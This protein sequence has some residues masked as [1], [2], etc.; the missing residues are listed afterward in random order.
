MAKKRKIEVEKGNSSDSSSVDHKDDLAE[1]YE[2]VS[3]GVWARRT[4]L[5]YWY[6][7]GC[8]FVDLLVA[9][10]I[11]RVGP[12]TWSASLSVFV[13]IV[14]L[15]IEILFYSFIWKDLRLPWRK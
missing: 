1:K 15:V 6:V 4:Y 3:W 11:A 7:V 14:L 5:K 12:K 8:V 10:E 9:L 2:D 13:L